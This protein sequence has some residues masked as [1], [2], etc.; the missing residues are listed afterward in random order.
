[1]QRLLAHSRAGAGFV[2]KLKDSPERMLATILL[3]NNLVN[4][5][6]S[7]MVAA[8]MIDMVDSYAVGITTGIVTLLILIFG[9][10]T[11]KSL[12]LTYNE[13]FACMAAP[14]IYYL[15]KV[16]APV[17][18][19]IEWLA[20]LIPKALGHSYKAKVLTH[21]D[22]LGMVE[23][24]GKEGVIKPAEEDLLTK[25]LQFKD[26][27]V[28]EV[29]TP[30]RR[31]IMLASKATVDDALTLVSKRNVSRIPVYEGTKD[32]VIGVAYLKELMAH[33]HEGLTS[34]VNIVTRPYFVP[35][36]AKLSQVLGQLQKRRIQMAIVVDEHG[37]V[38]GLVTI[39]DILE[40]V[41]GEIHDE[42]EPVVAPI[43]RMGRD[44]W[45]IDASTPIEL[46]NK[47]MGTKFSKEGQ[48]TIGGLLLER[49]GRIPKEGES[50]KQDGCNLTVSA[51]D[52]R[53]ILEI[54]GHKKR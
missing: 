54:T 5:A 39:E 19:V 9:E 17:V 22:I 31:M 49:F 16:S 52:A 6:A 18:V 35:E 45:R 36:S 48:N 40:E 34:L 13:G 51:A 12:A 8:I 43:I 14:V 23:L 25:A 29:A 24:A 4:V 15:S 3:G 30:Y 41:V 44:R 27:A 1:V 42:R 11:P 7:A 53:Q 10:I 26:K 50:I 28:S 32:K 20:S 37:T 21:E 38:S 33:R 2:K 47:V 46:I